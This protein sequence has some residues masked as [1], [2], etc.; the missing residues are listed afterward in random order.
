MCD[1]NKDQIPCDHPEIREAQGGVC[2][3][4]QTRICQGKKAVQDRP[5]N[6]RENRP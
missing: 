6:D 2:S 3:P 4:E 5:E 1:P